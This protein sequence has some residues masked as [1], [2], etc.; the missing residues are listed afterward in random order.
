V[1]DSAGSATYTS[2]V[3]TLLQ[4]LKTGGTTACY[5]GT[6]NDAPSTDTDAFKLI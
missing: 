4:I 2:P 5:A 6:G 1:T 3:P